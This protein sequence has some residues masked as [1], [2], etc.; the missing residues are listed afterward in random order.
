MVYI[1]VAILFVFIAGICQER[2]GNS[3]KVVPGDCNFVSV[4]FWRKT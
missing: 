3:H 2:Q 1:F 4:P